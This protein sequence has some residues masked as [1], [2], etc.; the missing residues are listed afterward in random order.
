MLS[1]CFLDF[2]VS[3]GVFFIG[4]GQ[5]SSFFS[6]LCYFHIFWIGPVK[7]E[8][9]NPMGHIVP[10]LVLRSSGI[11]T[12][13]FFVERWDYVGPLVLTNY[14]NYFLKHIGAD[15]TVSFLMVLFALELFNRHTGVCW[16]CHLLCNVCSNAS[17]L[18]PI[19]IGFVTDIQVDDTFVQ[20]CQ[21]INLFILKLNFLSRWQTLNHISN[22]LEKYFL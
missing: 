5:I 15:S 8:I 6:L 12:V 22:L 11:D 9:L 7:R 10:P 19:R 13:F 21:Y 14:H 1:R 18:F 2:S 16:I 3:L 17:L 20:Q 4:L